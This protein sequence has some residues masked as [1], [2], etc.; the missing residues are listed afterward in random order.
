MM[1]VSLENI[2]PI[3]SA[4]IEL[5]RV[6]VLYGANN[7]GKTTVARA[8][9]VAL[10]AL[11]GI[12]MWIT[13]PVSLINNDA[14]IGRIGIIISNADPIIGNAKY[15]IE[16]QR[17]E[18]GK[19]KLRV[20]F[21]SDNVNSD[22]VLYENELSNVLVNTGLHSHLLSVKRM[23]W[24]EHHSMSL[25]Y[26]G[27]PPHSLIDLHHL[28]PFENFHKSVLP[29]DI[30]ETFVTKIHDAFVDGVIKFVSDVSKVYPT[31]P[32]DRNSML[33]DFTDGK[34]Y[35]TS[36]EVASGV[37]RL[38]LIAAAIEL[39]KILPNTLVFIENIEDSLS[40]D[41]VNAVLD[42]LID[43]NVPVII[44][45][46]SL[47]VLAKAYMKK[48]NY[49]VFK[50]GTATNKL[51]PTLFEEERAIASQLAEIFTR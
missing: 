25:T 39:A 49:Y 50:D 44:E 4:E 36:L 10:K 26:M 22:R 1:R 35:Y 16:I 41:T 28:F 6:T 23:I 51:D 5:G 43:S 37:I 46:H 40:M 7:T 19:V 2:G 9:A 17:L 47:H 20:L 38:T 45:T 14:G 42:K 12:T 32:R 8:L 11:Q 27:G 30:A 48:L 15:V 33:P 3:K 13:E 24:V 34:H 21:R 18:T 31:R 29:L